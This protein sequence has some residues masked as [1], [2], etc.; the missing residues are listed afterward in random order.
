MTSPWHSARA[1]AALVVLTLP[2]WAVPARGQ[3]APKLPVEPQAREHFERGIEL[4]RGTFYRE[5]LN[6]FQRSYELDPR[7][8][9][10][11]SMGQAARGMG[12][13]EKATEYFRAFLRTF[14]PARQIEAARVQMARCEA[15]RLR[16]EGLVGGAQPPPAMTHVAPTSRQRWGLA[17]GAAALVDFVSLQAGGELRL[18]Y[19]L[20]PF[21][22]VGAAVVLGD[23]M[24]G[25]VLV[26]LQPRRGRSW[27]IRPALELRG[28]LHLV[29]RKVV[30][31]G[32]AWLGAN[33]EAGPGR[34]RPGVTVEGYAAPAGYYTYAVLL[35]IGYAV[36][37]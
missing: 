11:Y 17:L 3:A 19:A 20:G 21:A 7:P 12:D 35:S 33:L 22:E 14:P 13:C 8:E 34:L 2:V 36:D 18:T 27:S 30:P 15:E 6:E 4:Y 23:S 24:G 5:A 29:T 37:L 28:A 26:G 9:L 25:R 10:L 16:A 31:G 32:G 1:L